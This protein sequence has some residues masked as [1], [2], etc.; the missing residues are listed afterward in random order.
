MKIDFNTDAFL[1]F[2]TTNSEKAAM[3]TLNGALTDAGNSSSSFLCQQ[4]VLTAKYLNM[5]SKNE[6]TGDQLKSLL[7]DLTAALGAELLQMELKERENAQ[8]LINSLL[9]VLKGALSVLIT[10][11]F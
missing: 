1:S 8:K 7:D 4:A 3:D 6:I 2:L 5:R 11:A 9:D 10:L